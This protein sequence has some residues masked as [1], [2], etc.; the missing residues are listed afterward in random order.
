AWGLNWVFANLLHAAVV[1]RGGRALLFPA[2]PGS[3]K[4]TLAASLACRGG[5]FL[6]DEFCVVQ[7][8]GSTVL[9]F[10]RPIPLK[11]VSIAV[12]RAFEPGAY[13]GPVFPTTR[14][15]DVAHVGVPAESVHRGREPAQIDAIVFPDFQAGA[16][17]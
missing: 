5:R 6:S 15:G 11:N 1:E 3:G 2:W 17:V 14:K 7:F 9:P 13:I 10:A 12:I 4:S 16:A 8:D